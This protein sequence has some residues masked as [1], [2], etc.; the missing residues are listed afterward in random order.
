[1]DDLTVPSPLR[2]TDEDSAMPDPDNLQIDLRSL[3]YTGPIELPRP[4]RSVSRES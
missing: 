4:Q 2:D 1:M 3:P